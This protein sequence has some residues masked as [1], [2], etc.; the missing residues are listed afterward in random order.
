MSTYDVEVISDIES[1]DNST[2]PSAVNVQPI[3]PASPQEPSTNSVLSKIVDALIQDLD[4]HQQLEAQ[5]LTMER[6]QDQ[7]DRCEREKR[8]VAQREV[9]DSE[10]ALR[11]KRES[12]YKDF[13]RQR[14]EKHQATI[15]KL[16]S[17]A[18]ILARKA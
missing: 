5:R 6:G 17:I 4:A 12:G 9:R 13:Y 3:I 2:V 18:E 15:A 16:A 11:E 1:E 14:A 10:L 7:D 8:D